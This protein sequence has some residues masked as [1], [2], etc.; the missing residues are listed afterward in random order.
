MWRMDAENDAYPIEQALI[1]TR[2]AS[3]QST[4]SGNIRPHSRPRMATI[5]GICNGVTYHAVFKGSSP[6][7]RLP[8]LARRTPPPAVLR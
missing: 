7:I 1:A 8:D 5:P 6:Q 3:Q 4:A 2:H